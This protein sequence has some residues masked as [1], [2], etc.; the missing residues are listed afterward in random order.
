MRTFG[1]MI[2]RPIW[3]ARYRTKGGINRISQWR[4]RNEIKRAR[5]RRRNKLARI[6]RRKNRA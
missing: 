2:R 4:R 1:G 6:S 3:D 5:N